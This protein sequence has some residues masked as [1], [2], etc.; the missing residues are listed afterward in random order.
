M[1]LVLRQHTDK[2]DRRP[3]RQLLIQRLNPGISSIQIQDDDIRLG[4]GQYCM[5]ATQVIVSQSSLS[6]SNSNDCDTITAIAAWSTSSTCSYREL[7]QRKRSAFWIS[8]AEADRHN[9]CTVMEIRGSAARPRPTAGEC[10]YRHRG[11][12]PLFYGQG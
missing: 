10:C 1:M 12:L 8:A 5:I 6:A 4:F 11:I 3:Q 7:R 2:S 9:P